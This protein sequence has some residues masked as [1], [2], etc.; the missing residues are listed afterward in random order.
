MTGTRGREGRAR[1]LAVLLSGTLAYALL[2]AL[3]SQI[4]QT[5]ET[6][7]G[8]TLRRFVLALPVAL[9]ALWALV[10]A[11]LPRRERAPAAKKPFCTIGA[12]ALILASFV[13][14]FLIEYPGSFMYDT[15][16]QTFQIASGEYDMFHPL[17]HTLLIRLCISL[18]GVLG[19]FERCAAAY[20]VL[21]MTAMAAAFSLLC[22]SVSRSF[23]R[24]AARLS[25]AFFCLYPAHMAFASNCTKDGLFAASFA[26]FL[27]Y[28]VERVV[29]GRMARRHAALMVLSGAL[30]CLLRNNM[31]YAML[32]WAALLLLAGGNLRRLGAA[33]M[34]CCALG[35]GVNHALAWAVGADGGSFLEMLSVP[36]Q[37][38][39]RARVWAPE[40]FD[41]EEKAVLDA[42]FA[43]AC[44]ELYEPTLADPVKNRLDEQA[45]R[46]NLDA[47]NDVY[48]SVGK[49]RPDVYL[50]AFLNLALPSLYPYSAYRVAQ[51]Y[52]EVGIQPGGV[53]TGPFGQAPLTQPGRF[54]AIREAL[55]VWLYD[56]GADHIPGVRWFFNC[57]AVFWLLLALLLRTA[58]RGAWD[59]V[60][61]LLLPALLWG[62]YLLGPVMQGRYLYPFVCALPLF[63]CCACAYTEKTKEAA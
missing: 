24:R 40:A 19:S 47:L 29:R 20:S 23:G 54:A 42:A 46:E 51:P 8:E 49:K 7:L 21:S 50:D 63:A 34:A 10:R 22:A 30:A 33:A 44:Y 4:D 55:K 32:V 39:S 53:L 2:F 16:R 26:L 36:I 60:A 57:G 56:T 61:V 48:V 38:L 59:R 28:A 62:T 45:V 1:R 3:G 31:I 27:A 6:A 17:A 18:Y 35:F 25:T 58:Y 13:P 15:Q 41:E 5:G 52:I 9:A 14:L 11:R 12:F 37:Q 43:P